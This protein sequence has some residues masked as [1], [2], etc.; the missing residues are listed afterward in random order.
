VGLVQDED[1]VEGLAADAADHPFAVGV[2]PRGLR[3]A[4]EDRHLLGLEDGVEGLA[5]LAV[6]VM[7]SSC[8]VV[9]GRRTDI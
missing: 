3:C 2:H 7:S 4:L 8:R 9:H 6:A 1:V 5:V